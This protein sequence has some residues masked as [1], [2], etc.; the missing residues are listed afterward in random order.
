MKG[1]THRTSPWTAIVLI[2]AVALLNPRAALSAGFRLPELS[3]AGLGTADTL[4]ANPEEIGALPYNPAAM[5]FQ[6]HHNLSVGVVF[7]HPTTSVRPEGGSGEVDDKAPS[8][9]TVPNFYAMGRL[10]GN[11]SAGLA[12]NAPFGLE[13]KWPDETF[14]GFAQLDPSDPATDLDPLEPS[15]TRLDMFNINPNIAYKIDPLGLSIALG[16]N[17]YVVNKANLDSQGIKIEGDGTGWGWNV[18]LMHVRGPISLGTSFRSKVRTGLDGTFDATRLGSTKSSGSTKLIFPYMWQIGGRYAVSPEL[19]LEF[20]F[21]LTGWSAF[22]DV[23]VS[24]SSPGIPS[25][26]TESENWNNSKTYHLGVTYQMNPQWQLR[27]GYGY[28]EG[29]QPDSHYSPR[30][31]DASRNTFTA[32]VKYGIERWA[33]EAG[34]LFEMFNKRTIDSQTPFLGGDSNGTAVYNGTYRSNASLFGIG[35]SYE[36]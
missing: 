20:D 3:I 5:S 8:W 28:D 1:F 33:F 22:R 24:H 12:V 7:I 34:Y 15:L 16:T 32:G 21:D 29:P 35:F 36:L 6:E 30:I 4:V 19:A 25:P 14:P 27:F 10:P 31:P 13:T 18:A 2:I 26:V 17:L 23:S 9:F 11:F